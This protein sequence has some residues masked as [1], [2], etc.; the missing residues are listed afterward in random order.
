MIRT[1][2]VRV[3]G[4]PIYLCCVLFWVIN[5]DAY[6]A[7][8]PF[9]QRKDVKAFIHSMVKKHHF[10]HTHL[11]SLFKQVKIRKQILKSIAKPLEQ[12]SWDT[13][14]MVFMTA[15]RIEHG[16]KYWNKHADTLKK[17]EQVYGVPAAIIVATLGVETKYGQRIGGH[18]VI[19]ALANLSFNRGRRSTYFKKE[20]ENFLLLTRKHRLD[21]LRIMG[22][23]AGAIGQPQF[24]PSS[25]LRYGVNFS[26]SGQLDLIH[27]EEDVIGSIANYY[28]EH[29]WMKD[30][31]VAVRAYLT[32]NRS[33]ILAKKSNHSRALTLAQLNRYGVM[34]IYQASSDD[35]RAKIILLESKHPEYW[36]SFH[37]FDVIK[38]YNSSNLY[39]MAVYQLSNYI[40]ELREKL[41]DAT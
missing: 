32:G 28:H 2:T 29:G 4:L 6:A 8:T 30:K 31:P 11:I 41:N 22:S 12:Q 35:A 14:Q 19:D 1:I 33:S 39:A 15:W 17:A 16:V 23:Y 3:H 18:R 5:H 37:N 36:L 34:P 20:L 40:A 10:N 25:Y 21:P 27:N 13:Y 24:M 7:D 38:R 26:K 9:I